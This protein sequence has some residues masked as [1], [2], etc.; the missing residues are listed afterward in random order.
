MTSWAGSESTADGQREKER[1]REGRGV[2]MEVWGG[3]ATLARSVVAVIH[4]AVIRGTEAPEWPSL[5]PPESPANGGGHAVIIYSPK[6]LTLDS[7]LITARGKSDWTWRV[8]KP[9]TL[10]SVRCL[11]QE[12]REE[13]LAVVRTHVHVA[14]FV[15]FNQVGSW[16]HGWMTEAWLKMTCGRCSHGP[17]CSRHMWHYNCSLPKHKCRK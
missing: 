8:P 12:V 6:L 9:V 5:F 13:A 14:V 11:Q 4:H 7:E 1:Q 16:R 15:Y 3:G 10:I 17:R 2:Q